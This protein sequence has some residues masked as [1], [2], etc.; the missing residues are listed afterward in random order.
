MGIYSC[1]IS[2]GIFLVY[3]VCGIYGNIFTIY[4]IFTIYIYIYIIDIIGYMEMICK[5]VVW[6]MNEL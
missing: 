6:N 3:M 5:L 2:I 4:P 1:N